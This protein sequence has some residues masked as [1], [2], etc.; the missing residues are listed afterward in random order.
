MSREAWIEAGQRVVAG[1]TTGI[2]CPVRDDAE[3]SVEWLPIE[4]GRQTN[5]NGGWT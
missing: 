4:S 1:D 3:L 2:R 5:G